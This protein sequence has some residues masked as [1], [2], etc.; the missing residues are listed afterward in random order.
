MNDQGNIIYPIQQYRDQLTRPD[1]FSITVLHHPLGW[2]D[3]ENSRQLRTEL[4]QCSSIVIFGHEHMTDTTRMLTPLGDHVRYIDGG[5][6]KSTGNEESS[7]NLILLDTESCKLKSLA[8]GRTRNRYE[9]EVTSD[10]EDATRL[11]SVESG[12]FRLRT[13]VRNM[14]EDIG[15]NVIHPRREE[16]TLRDLFVYPDLVPITDDTSQTQERFERSVSAETLIFRDEASHIVLEGSGTSGKSALLRMLFSEYYHRG[17][18]PLYVKG[19]TFRPGQSHNLRQVLKKVFC[20]TYAGED[21]TEYERLAQSERV[22][23]VDD[24]NF[25]G[26][27]AI[28]HRDALEYI[29]A[30]FGDAILVT[31]DTLPLHRVLE[32]EDCKDLATRYQYYHI[33]EFGHVKRDELIKRWI[34]L[35]RSSRDWNSA[36]LLKERDHARNV[37]NTTIGRNFMPSFPVIVLIILQSRET[38]S[39]SP[40]GS[41]Y[42]HHYQFLITRSLTQCGVTPQDMDAVANYISE[43]AYSAFFRGRVREISDDEYSQWHVEFCCEYGV[44]WK[45]ATML[46]K[47]ERGR[48]LGREPTGQVFFKYQYVYFFFLAKRLARSL[49]EEAG[50]V[51]RTAYERAIAYRRIRQRNSVSNSPFER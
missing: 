20:D 1:G 18:I 41:T 27:D 22:L 17:K 9:A 24:F 38:G 14:M 29:Q 7:F 36:S 47:L 40:I 16:L 21:F 39:A 4:S 26:H 12:R 34:L 46:E 50:T 19:L 10:W 31:S 3:P 51:K 28:V 13:G 5:V 25:T 49:D 23:L 42:G 35:G 45:S 37:M 44:R 6:L 32:R 33:R 48:I 15:I 30:F 8:F 43:L 11:T 2:F